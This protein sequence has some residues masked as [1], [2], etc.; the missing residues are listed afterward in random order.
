V[1]AG[2][3]E[4]GGVCDFDSEFMKNLRHA[5][6]EP[7]TGSSAKTSRE[8]NRPRLENRGMRS[9]VRRRVISTLWVAL[10]VSAAWAGDPG[11]TAISS[12]TDLRIVR[13]RVDS[14]SLAS[15]GYDRASHILE[16]EFHSG[17]IY[18]YLA[19]PANVADELAAAESKGR[20]FSQHIRGKYEFMRID[21][22][23]K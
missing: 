5:M 7:T 14:T 3:F 4:N 13:V 21:K 20:Y 22:P 12:R 16:V 11:A 17:A 19:V 2:C 8:P 10:F 23:A 9:S 1:L 6:P 18:R 15:A